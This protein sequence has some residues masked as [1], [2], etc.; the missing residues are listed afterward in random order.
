M[1]IA[2]T[3]LTS[4][5]IRTGIGLSHIQRTLLV[6]IT[7]IVYTLNILLHISSE[8]LCFR[9]T[10]TNTSPIMKNQKYCTVVLSTSTISRIRFQSFASVVYSDLNTPMWAL[11]QVWWSLHAG[12]II[13]LKSSGLYMDIHV[14]GEYTL[15]LKSYFSH[16]SKPHSFQKECKI[17]T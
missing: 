9:W 12:G 17:H 15:L 2:R 4:T 7:G 13:C 5:G 10:H 3:L 6:P 16:K 11:A 1:S 8:K 14:F